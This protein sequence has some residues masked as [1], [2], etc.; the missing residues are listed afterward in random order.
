MKLSILLAT[1]LILTGAQSAVAQAT[2]DDQGNVEV[3]RGAFTLRTG[4]LTNSSRIP[5]PTVLPPAGNTGSVTVDT[6]KLAP[7]SIDI[8]P[9]LDFIN[10]SVSDSAPVGTT[11][12]VDQDSLLF[13]VEIG[14]ER[15]RGQHGYGEGVEVNTYASEELETTQSAF[16]RGDSVT[17]L[18]GVAL[19]ESDSV[20]TEFGAD[21]R[22]QVRALNIRTN[23]AALTES[24]I[25]F[26]E[27]GGIIVEDLQGGGDNDFADGNFVTLMNGAGRGTAREEVTTVSDSQETTETTLPDSVR[28]EES[29]EITESESTEY[30][31]VDSAISTTRQPHAAGAVSD[32]GEQL[33]YSTYSN[34]GE[35][36]AGS[37]G[38][39]LSGQTSPLDSNPSAP[40]TLINGSLNYSDEVLSGTVGITQFLG[41][42]HEAAT[43]INGREVGEGIVTP[44]GL[45]N[46]QQ[47]V[48]YV[49][50]QQ[51]PYSL[52]TR[53][54][55]V[56]VNGS[57]GIG[58]G[59]QENLTTFNTSTQ[60]T[61]DTFS[62]PQGQVEI[63]DFQTT[64]VVAN[65]GTVNFGINDS[66]QL[67]GIE[68]TPGAS[69]QVSSDTQET[70]RTV[71]ILS[72]QEMLTDSSTS[73]SSE[74]SSDSQNRVNFSSLQGELALGAVLN[75][76]NTPW[77]AAANTIRAEVFVN[78]S[79][80]GQNRDAQ[81]GIRLEALF[82]PFGE[83]QK[84][85]YSM[86]ANGNVTPIYQTVATGTTD[87]IN[88]VDVAVNEFVL[89]ELGNR[90]AQTTGTGN[91]E[92]PGIYARVQQVFNQGLEF[93]GGVKFSF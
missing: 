55:G 65:T 6:T 10:Q 24:G 23:R 54:A 4:E 73:E 11:R 25:Y 52:T 71:S 38:I 48:G 20:D 63:V 90:A 53:A 7:N 57:L 56:Y 75:V 61:V 22:V 5:L 91:P 9:N 82:H 83:V 70:G 66:G 15:Q 64:D 84:D 8:T 33:V 58:I 46:N 19:P 81:S 44:T 2:R 80:I 72:G 62:T 17:K 49:P 41:A 3:N 76:G 88:G 27:D 86:D 92:G 13:N 60:T 69:E 68:F 45:L 87:N 59:N 34:A 35:V 21:G 77:T 39:T 74:S 14:V 51:Q 32:T 47:W 1:L 18:Q 26:N 12:T 67:T 29:T 40:P 30:G 37:D 42:T 43:D 36:R 78:D 31:Q 28:T 50:G 93:I 79:L 85:A 89:D 16:V